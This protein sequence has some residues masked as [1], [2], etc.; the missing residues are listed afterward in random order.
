MGDLEFW[1]SIKVKCN[2]AFELPIYDFLL[3]SNSNYMSNLHRSGVIATRKFFSCLL[4]LGPNFD[5]NP[6]PPP[7]HPSP[8]LT[9]GW[10][11]SKLNGFPPWVRRKA[12]TKNEVDQFNIFWDILLTDTQKTHTQTNGSKEPRAG[13]NKTFQAENVQSSATVWQEDPASTGRLIMNNPK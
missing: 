10:F 1:R 4:S 5:P 13:F 2:G 6:H 11:F 12:S 9:P 3:V 8:T 7:H